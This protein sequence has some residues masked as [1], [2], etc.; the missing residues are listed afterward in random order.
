[1][2]YTEPPLKRIVGNIEEIFNRAT[3]AKDLK[4][5]FGLK[6]VDKKK[7]KIAVRDNSIA[8]CRPYRYLAD[9][10]KRMQVTCAKGC[11][12]KR[13]ASYIKSSESW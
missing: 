11:P 4:W 13:W 8:T 9:D 10:K 1:M 3:P 6:I 5:E 12:F 7:F 2:C